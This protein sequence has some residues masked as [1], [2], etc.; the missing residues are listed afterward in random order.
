M[1]DFNQ[2]ADLT[3]T[4]V[5]PAR[6]PCLELARQAWNTGGSA[7]VVLNAANEEAVAAF[8]AHKISFGAIAEV[9]DTTLAETPVMAV[10]DVAAIL[11]C[12]RAARRVASAHCGA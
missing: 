1:L 2:L 8:L 5:D 12:D 9:V 6:Y 4:S 10:D 7:P 11:S 3:F